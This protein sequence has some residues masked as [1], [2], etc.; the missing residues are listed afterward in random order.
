M[1]K[2]SEGKEMFKIYSSPTGFYPLEQ[3]FFFFSG[4]LIEKKNSK[5]MRRQKRFIY[6][7]IN[8]MPF[9]VLKIALKYLADYI[10]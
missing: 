4:A 6:L 1:F 9:R 2:Y 10:F 8:L 5:F 3:F 7:F